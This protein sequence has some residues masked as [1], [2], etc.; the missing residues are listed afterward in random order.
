MNRFLEMMFK[1]QSSSQ[2]DQ[3]VRFARPLYD[4]F[5][6][7]HFWYYRIT[8]SGLYSYAGT[9]GSWNEYSF[10]E[11]LINHFPCLRSPSVLKGGLSLMKAGNNQ[12]YAQVLK[13]AW[14]K[15]RIHFNINL[16][17]PCADG[18]EAFGFG[19]KFSDHESDERILNGLPLLRCFFHQFRKKHGKLFTLLQDN[20]ID[21]SEHMGSTFYEQPKSIV[22]PLNRQLFLQDIGCMTISQLTMR[23]RDILR[24]L[25]NGYPASYIKEELHLGLR[26]VENYIASIKNKLSCR[27]KVELIKKAQEVILSGIL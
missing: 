25:A 4:H 16:F 9:N 18:I 13:T 1:I 8:H 24:L 20:C 21:L 11:S 17:E 5:G 3:M 12:A 22:L 2:Y 27:S 10:G 14:D 6:I 7:N 23:E 19:S 26:T 15:F